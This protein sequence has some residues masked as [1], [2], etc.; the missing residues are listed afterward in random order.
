MRI[1]KMLNN[2]RNQKKKRR[3]E[4]LSFIYSVLIG[5]LLFA[6]LC[7]NFWGAGNEGIRHSPF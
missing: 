1:T 2:V 5:H 6:T 7:A 3:S 4:A